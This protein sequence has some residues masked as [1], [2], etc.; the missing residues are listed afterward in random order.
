MNHFNKIM[1]IAAIFIVYPMSG[2]ALAT[3]HWVEF[4]LI[5]FGQMPLLINAIN[6]L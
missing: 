5:Y 6:K 4:S 3:G 1:V 2:I